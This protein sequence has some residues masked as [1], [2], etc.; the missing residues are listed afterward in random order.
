[1]PID[2]SFKG[3]APVSKYQSSEGRITYSSSAP[4]PSQFT[5]LK[6]YNFL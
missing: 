6:S 2:D 1:M 3:S 4:P 5:Y